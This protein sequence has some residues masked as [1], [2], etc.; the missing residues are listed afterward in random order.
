MKFDLKIMKFKKYRSIGKQE[1]IAATKVIKSGKLSEFVAG[2]TKEFYGGKQVQKFENYLKKFYKVKYA[3]T[4]N[5]WTSGLVACVG[6]LDLEPG[7]E[8]ITTPWTMCATSTAILHWNAIPVFADIDENT[9]NIDP[10]DVAKKITKRT[11]AIIAAD[12]FGYPCDIDALKKITNNKN[13]K[14]ITD[15]A[16]S[17]FS[18]YKKK[19]YWNFIRYWRL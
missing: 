17:P 15:S 12:I 7:D 16:Q 18:K 13:I 8:I 6:C 19:N 14:I 5:S 1:L 4:F 9:F 2:H 10:A 11:R 3:L